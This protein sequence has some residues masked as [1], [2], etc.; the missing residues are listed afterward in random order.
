MASS[1]VESS[2][3]QV[4]FFKSFSTSMTLRLQRYVNRRRSLLLLLQYFGFLA[5]VYC[6]YAVFVQQLFQFNPIP[7]FA[8]S[9]SSFRR[10]GFESFP[11]IGMRGGGRGELTV[12][13][14]ATTLNVFDLTTNSSSL[15]KY[16][17]A[18]YSCS[19]A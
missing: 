11:T 5:A 4:F 12:F 18:L 19:V 7:P 10:F 14:S 6:T 9:Q 15:V 2:R 1:R 17:V 3:I 16:Q 13:K 8:V